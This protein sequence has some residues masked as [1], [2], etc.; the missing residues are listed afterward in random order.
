MQR[1]PPPGDTQ[2][3]TATGSF[4]AVAV[5][6]GNCTHRP[7]LHG[8]LDVPAPPAQAVDQSDPTEFELRIWSCVHPSYVFST[9]TLITPATSRKNRMTVASDA[10]WTAGTQP[11]SSPHKASGSRRPINGKRA[12]FGTSI[13][14]RPA[15]RSSK[16]SG[17]AS[18]SAR[19]LQWSRVAPGSCGSARPDATPQPRPFP[20]LGAGCAGARRF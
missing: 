11:H 16:A 12:R 8:V 15:S 9:L 2:R 6:R 4:V 13:E 3:V 1:L 7:A 20:G 14:R 5:N 17:E 10:E 18:V 19:R